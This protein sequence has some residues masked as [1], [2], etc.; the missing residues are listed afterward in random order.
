MG[1]MTEN[2]KRPT[3]SS[4]RISSKK[5]ISYSI[6]VNEKYIY[7]DELSKSSN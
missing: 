4:R 6:A 1:V 2:S 3:S 7:Q 5:H